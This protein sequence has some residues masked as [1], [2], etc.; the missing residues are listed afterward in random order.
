M[1]VGDKT[2][3]VLFMG[4]GQGLIRTLAAEH[5]HLSSNSQHHVKSWVR[6]S[7][8]LSQYKVETGGS[9]GLASHQNQ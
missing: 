7:T 9:L 3:K 1:G 2:N 6:Q 5:E 8:P 4:W